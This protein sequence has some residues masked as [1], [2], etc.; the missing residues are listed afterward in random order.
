MSKKFFITGSSSTIGKKFIG[1]LPGD[2]KIYCPSKKE[3]DMKNLKKLKQLKSKILSHDIFILLHSVIIPKKHISK[4]ENEI[5]DQLKINLLSILEISEMA[6]TFNK[7]ARIFILGSESGKKGSFDII[8]GLSKTAIHQYIRE[9]RILYPS[10]QIVGVSPSTIIDG[11]I[12]L[13][14]KDKN[15]VKK[16]ILKNPKKRGIQSFEISKLLYSLIYHNT[17]YISNTV[18]DVDGGKFARMWLLINSQQWNKKGIKNY[19]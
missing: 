12:T 19:F 17:D 13:K 18:I 16:S 8:Y 2:S 11:R 3:L 6:L 4:K 9:R 14:R 5:V 1:M 15:N 7:K 10:Q